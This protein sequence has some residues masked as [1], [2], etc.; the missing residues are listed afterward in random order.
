MSDGDSRE[1]PAR[2]IAAVGAIVRKGDAVLLIRRGKPPRMGEW[3]IPGGAVEV[4]E[5]WREATA[6]E[7]REEC[8]IEI[9]V[10]EVAEVLEIM[11]RD[12]AGRIQYHYAIVDFNARY[13]GGELKAATDVSEAVWVA[14]RELDGYPMN[15]KTRE[16]ILK[17]IAQ[18]GG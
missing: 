6:R 9:E 13:A 1:Y 10:G 11:T 5:T 15:P 14:P 16:V 7:L 17:A 8:G 12:D 18:T 4:G 2:P 3:S